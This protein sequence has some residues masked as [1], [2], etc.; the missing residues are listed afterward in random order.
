MAITRSSLHKRRATGGK[1]HPHQKK[2]KFLSGRPPAM[3][4][5]GD[6]RIHLVRGRGNNTKFRALRLETG[7]FSWGSEGASFLVEY[8]GRR[9]SVCF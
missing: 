1:R 2:R 6:K 3:T 5:L 9:E 4:K 7:N 8:I